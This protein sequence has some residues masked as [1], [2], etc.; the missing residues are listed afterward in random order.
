MR[1]IIINNF[2][3]A[4]LLGYYGHGCQEECKCGAHPCD[5]VTGECHC[6][7]GFSG[8]HCDE[9]KYSFAH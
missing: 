9:R 1:K 2:F 8:P 7:P 4:C 5:P 6:P 3:V